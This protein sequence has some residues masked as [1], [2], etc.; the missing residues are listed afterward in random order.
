MKL[1]VI[2]LLS[3][4]IWSNVLCAVTYNEEL[5]TLMTKLWNLDVNRCEPPKD[6]RIDIQ[7]YVTAMN[8][9]YTDRASRNLYTFFNE[10]EIFNKPTFKA[11]RALLDNYETETN[12]PEV[13][14]NEEKREIEN[15]MTAIMSTEIMKEAHRFLVS[16]RKASQSMA[17]F[18]TEVQNIWFKLYKRTREDRFIN[19]CGFEHV[20]VGEKRSRDISGFHNWVQVYLQE[21]A[22][23][24][25]YRG[26]FRR[27]TTEEIEA[28]PRMLSLQF[29]WKRQAGKS[30][31]SIFMGTS[32]E[33]EL[34]MYTVVFMMGFRQAPAVHVKNYNIE[35]MTYAHG[36][37]VGSAFPRS[38]HD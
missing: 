6:F 14:T 21:K 1:L 36:R 34:A 5:S 30:F 7:G 33:F 8:W 11:M 4:T 25:D 27:G 9:T 2:I 13:E 10:T 18:K 20:F 29:V 37:E 3:S 15:F 12:L 22:G 19:S 23:N 38:L 17:A 28:Q 16:K 31:T 24:L 35:V 32:P 26:Y